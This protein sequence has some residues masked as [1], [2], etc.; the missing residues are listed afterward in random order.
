MTRRG[1]SLLELTVVCAIIGILLA[2]AAPRFSS[3]RDRSAARSA[4]ADLA[5]TLSTA[6]RSAI[7]R[8]GLVAVVFDTINGIIQVRAGGQVILRRELRAAYG[9]VLASNRDSMVYDPRG[10][11]YGLA[12]LTVT[13]RSGPIVDTLTMSRLGRVRW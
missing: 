7:L 10:L 6:R 12:N 5:A 8:R 4:A 13:V 11:G 3:A 2:L 1:F 9:I